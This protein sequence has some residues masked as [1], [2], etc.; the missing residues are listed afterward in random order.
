[1]IHYGGGLFTVIFSRFVV[2]NQLKHISMFKN[3][4]CIVSVALLVVSC[5]NN[6]G[7][8]ENAKV[9]SLEVKDLEESLAEF[10]ACKNAATESHACKEYT[11][12]AISKYYGYDLKDT[13]NVY[14]PYD[15]IL[16]H[17]SASNDWIEL[18]LANDQ[19]VLNTAQKNA[20]KGIGTIAL[21]I[22]S[23]SIAIVINGKLSHSNSLNLD[24][25]SVTVFRPRKFNKSFVGKGINY[26]WSDL[27]TVKIYSLK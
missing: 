27:S 2:V 21:S 8:K 16:A 12:L 19:S 13:D 17:V 20:N 15:E 26:A 23:N 25:P 5:G 22:K 3:I 18:G 14:L 24:C 4:I 9:A 10:I 1:M 7:S 6:S 11:A